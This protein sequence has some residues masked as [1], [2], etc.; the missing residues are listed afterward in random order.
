M[1]FHTEHKKCV[2]KKD[3]YMYELIYNL[4]SLDRHQFNLSGVK[5]Y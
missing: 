4:E 5:K 1:S 2:T 3:I